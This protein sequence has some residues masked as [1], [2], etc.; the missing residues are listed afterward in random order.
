MKNYKKPEVE[1]VDFATEEITDLGGDAV[2]TSKVE[3]G[4][5][6]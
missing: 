2:L 5:G 6:D 4:N 1:F 3:G